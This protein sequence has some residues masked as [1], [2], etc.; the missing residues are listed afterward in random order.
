MVTLV[1]PKSNK[2]DASRIIDEI[3]VRNANKPEEGSIMFQES[4]IS[5]NGGYTNI[6]RRVHFQAG[7]IEDLKILCKEM[8]LKLGVGVTGYKILVKESITPFFEGQD[9][10]INPTTLEIMKSQGKDIYRKTVLA[11]V[12]STETDELLANDKVG[13]TEPAKVSAS[14]TKTETFKS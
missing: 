10:K 14:S 3:I 4:H 11:S 8:K 6:Q 7:K 2:V 9:P 13:V 1:D 5:L 12:N